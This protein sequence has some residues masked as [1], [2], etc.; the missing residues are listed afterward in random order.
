MLVNDGLINRLTDACLDVIM[1]QV[2]KKSPSTII[3]WHL[4]LDHDFLK[5][6]EQGF[7]LD[8]VPL[9]AVQVCHSVIYR[10]RTLCKCLLS[11]L[12]LLNWEIEHT[13]ASKRYIITNKTVE[14]YSA[15]SNCYYYYGTSTEYTRI[16]GWV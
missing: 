6:H 16:F 12:L 7:D 4:C 13:M 1:E 11:S 9:K 15:A 5:L 2:L 14:L 10:L 3:L 8:K